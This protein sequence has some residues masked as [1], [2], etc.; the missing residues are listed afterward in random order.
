MAIAKRELVAHCGGNP[1][2][3]QL[4]LIE[5]AC[6]LKL[7]LSVMDRAFAERGGEQTELDSRTYLAWSNSFT[8][9][10]ARLGV[11]AAPAP[12]PSLSDY[13]GGLD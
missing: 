11:E 9:T 2:A 7:R 13:L 12:A 4:S 8:R 3:T 10:L 1:S 5:Q 6:Q